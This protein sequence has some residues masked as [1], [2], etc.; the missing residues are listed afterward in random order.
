MKDREDLPPDVAA[1]LSVR[2][3]RGNPWTERDA[4]VVAKFAGYTPI[5]RWP[6]SVGIAWPGIC[7]LGHPCRPTFANVLAGRRPCGKN[8]HL[9]EPVRRVT[10]KRG[11]GKREK[12]Q[13]NQAAIH[14]LA[15]NRGD[16]VLQT[17]FR[18]IRAGKSGTIRVLCLTLRYPCG[19]ESR[20]LGVTANKYKNN[21]GGCGVCKP[22]R[23]LPGNELATLRPD[24]AAELVDPSLGEILASKS[25]KKVWW[26][27]SDC[28]NEWRCSVAN[29]T[30][31]GSGCPS[32]NE[33]FGYN[34]ALPGM[35][36]VVQGVSK[37]SREV[38]IKAGI[39]NNPE[40]RLYD[41]K[42]RGLDTLLA[43]LTWREGT[44]APAVERH[45]TQKI[46]RK[47]PEHLIPTKGDLIDGYR[48][49][50]IDA[51]ESRAAIAALLEF[52]RGFSP[53]T[54]THEFLGKSV[55]NRSTFRST[56]RERD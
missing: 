16:V 37:S 32:C 46:R 31:L 36:Y 30:I 22:T 43:S 14:E 26:R 52:A 24:V 13:Q 56:R 47:L 6:G 2:R 15:I 4:L 3:H 53:D 25:Q 5:G 48:E 7:Q 11:L 44:V 33:Q 20:Q 17:G 23:L 49:A 41:H 19:H 27:C 21:K 12:S 1:L 51:D 9:P 29:R 42:R 55:Y 8:G 40:H 54:L 35:L 18:E 10:R 38:I 34:E 50:V 39:T 45:W 28:G